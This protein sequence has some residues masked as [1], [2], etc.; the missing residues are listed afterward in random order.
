MPVF[1]LALNYWLHLLATVTWLGGL[2]MLVLVAWPEI[3]RSVTVGIS[4]KETL[5]ASIEKRFRTLSNI[6][7]VVLLVTG[8]IQMDGDAHYEGFLT[9]TNA[10]S[11]SLLA[12]H[13]VVLLMLGVAAVLQWGV[14]PALDR[15]RLVSSRAEQPHPEAQR[16]HHH[17]R[18]LTILNLALGLLVLIFTAYMT[19]L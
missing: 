2:V 4:E 17:L 11:I 9:I 18:N 3:R 13:I 7:L 16:Q 10:W 19:A 5:L 12:K 8:M 15:A 14:Q 1:A 6:S